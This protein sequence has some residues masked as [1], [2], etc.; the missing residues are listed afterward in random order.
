MSWH[1]TGD[2]LHR[3]RPSWL[4]QRLQAVASLDHQP[5]GQRPRFTPRRGDLQGIERALGHQLQ[6]QRLT[7]TSG[8]H[9]GRTNPL[10]EAHLRNVAAVAHLMPAGPAKR[11]LGKY[12]HSR[13]PLRNID[14]GPP[15]VHL[16]EQHVI[17]SA[18]GVAPPG[19]A[20]QRPP[21]HLSQVIYIGSDLLQQI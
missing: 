5:P 15:A 2:E 12:A 17:D 6:L 18:R 20:I 7:S 1:A 13:D 14:R 4:K 10:L 21:T 8:K 11:L 3:S 19:H 16:H 9:L